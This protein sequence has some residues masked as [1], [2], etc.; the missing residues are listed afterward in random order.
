[1]SDS[2][3]LSRLSDA[4]IEE[5]EIEAAF[6]PWRGTEAKNT[7]A[8]I[9][10]LRAE[11]AGCAA[12]R[13]ENKEIYDVGHREGESCND[14]DWQIALDD[15]FDGEVVTPA[16]VVASVVR[17]RERCAALRT[18]LTDLLE[19]TRA[20]DFAKPGQLSREEG[21]ALIHAGDAARAALEETQTARDS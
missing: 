5:I 7:L 21:W 12:L 3:S 13:A 2:G 20:I 8:L 19:A 9:A 17:E 1:M 15:V 6:M 10:E 4:V 16:S 14:A 11:R 18:A